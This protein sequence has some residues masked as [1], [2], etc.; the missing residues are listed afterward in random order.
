MNTAK[1]VRRGDPNAKSEAYPPGA[2]LNLP[3]TWTLTGA[4]GMKGSQC[5]WFHTGDCEISDPKTG[6]PL[7]AIMPGMGGII[8]IRDTPRGETWSIGPDVLW[9]MYQHY[10]AQLDGAYVER[11]KQDD[12]ERKKWHDTVDRKRRSKQQKAETK[13]AKNRARKDRQR[14]KEPAVKAPK[15]IPEPVDEPK[16]YPRGA[17][18]SALHSAL[19]ALEEVNRAAAA[20]LG[21]HLGP[22][23]NTG[24][25]LD[26]YLA[27]PD[28]TMANMTKE[29]NQSISGDPDLLYTIFYNGW[30]SPGG[31]FAPCLYGNHIPA[32][33]KLASAEERDA[34]N[35]NAEHAL[36]QTGWAK[37]TKGKWEWVQRPTEA[38]R[39]YILSWYMDRKL[40]IDEEMPDD[41]RVDLED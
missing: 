15:A 6:E 27:D 8:S 17:T 40:K 5:M 20:E 30:L 3:L 37:V 24:D 29:V 7:G 23:D 2:E 26:R 11:M 4:D 9:Y 18:P 12:R 21:I 28:G 14:V 19:H 25:L 38:Q 33:H 22:G 16:P 35:G 32:A 13:V 36:E 31:E 41:K 10:R 34:H 39:N 1:R